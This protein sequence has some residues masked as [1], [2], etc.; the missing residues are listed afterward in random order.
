MGAEGLLGHVAND[1]VAH[2]LSLLVDN[3]LGEGDRLRVQSHV[4]GCA[5]CAAEVTRLGRLKQRVQQS[6]ALSAAPE[7]LRRSVMRQLDHEPC[8]VIPRAASIR[9]RP[10]PVAAGATALGIA[11][12][13]WFG[14]SGDDGSRDLVARYARQLPLEFLSNDARATEAWLADKVDFKVRVP[15]PGRPDLSLLGAR[16]SHV[17]EH[18]AVQLTYGSGTS[19]LRRI[20]VFVFED[21]EARARLRGTV[22]HLDDRDFVTGSASGFNLAQWHQNQVVYSLIAEEPDDVI[23]LVRAVQP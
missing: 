21:P 9:W 19:G 14:R 22:R 6:C 2:E 20:S 3:E 18:P 23:E 7:G 10:I 5:R 13:I 4:D 12:W 16:L 15:R 11:A 17:R 8:H 1:C